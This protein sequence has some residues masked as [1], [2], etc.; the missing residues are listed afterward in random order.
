MKKLRSKLS[1]RVFG[2]YDETLNSFKS[3]L[4]RAEFT[5]KII[6]QTA[7]EMPNWLAKTIEKAE[8]EMTEETPSTRESRNVYVYACGSSN[9]IQQHKNASRQSST[10]FTRPRP[11]RKR[12]MHLFQDV[13]RV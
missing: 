8:Q 9:S 6:Q 11:S 5:Q 13:L 7:A 2:M 10:I 1:I 12:N 3:Q 4:H